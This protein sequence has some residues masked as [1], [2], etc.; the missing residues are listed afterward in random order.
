MKPLT[1][2]L[3]RQRL[4]KNSAESPKNRR[5]KSSIIDPRLQLFLLQDALAIRTFLSNKLDF[6]NI[7]I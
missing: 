1:V 6:L 3:F 7:A 4:H 2:L 5:K